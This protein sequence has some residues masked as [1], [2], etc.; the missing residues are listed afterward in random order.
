[1]LR[2]IGYGIQCELAD[3]PFRL[4]TPFAM[5]KKIS[6]VPIS[7]KNWLHVTLPQVYIIVG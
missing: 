3:V 1:M 7:V 5:A 2:F 4:K 6:Q